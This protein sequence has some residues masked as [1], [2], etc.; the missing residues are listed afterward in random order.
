MEE[1]NESIK[2][3]NRKHLDLLPENEKKKIEKSNEISKLMR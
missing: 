2:K 1:K 3:Y